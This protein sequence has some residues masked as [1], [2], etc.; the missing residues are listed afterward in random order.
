MS[1]L[2]TKVVV[3]EQVLPFPDPP[4]TPPEKTTKSLELVKVMGWY[5][6][7]GKGNHKIGSKRVLIEPDSVIPLWLEDKAWEGSKISRPSN[8]RI[9]AIKLRG[10]ISPGLLM[11]LE[12]CGLDPLTPVGTE[13]HDLLGIKKYVQPE[14]AQREARSKKQT[15]PR[16][17]HSDFVKMTDIENIKR[18][19]YEFEDGE[20]VDISIKLHGTS[21]RAGWAKTAYERFL[22][23]FVINTDR[24]GKKYI[25]WYIQ[26]NVRVL[27]NR[28]KKFFRLMPE[29]E[30]VVGSR[31][32]E[33]ETMSDSFYDENVWQTVSE[34][35]GLKDILNPGE[36]VYGEIVG[37][38]KSGK[39]VQKNFSYGFKDELAL[40]AYDVRID[41]RWLDR[42]EFYQF[43]NERGI[44]TVTNIYR[45]PYS[46]DVIEK[47][48][49]DHTHPID[50]HNPCREGIVV[51]PIKERISQRVGRLVLKAISDKYYLANTT[52][53]Q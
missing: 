35:N 40:F 38:M 26:E 20:T 34:H 41:G 5:L 52:E 39:S 42:D 2:S 50:K 22:P 9:R 6:V 21:F 3:V 46:F 7:A 8:G 19:N 33:L 1:T 16:R 28:I 47:L 14:Q 10:V 29:N 31:N 37:T 45:G 23:L 18:Y 43:C 27:K 44:N 15:L 11:S 36:F 51:R 49:N 53:Y 24:R 48:R 32:T 25:K 17:L 4:N 13:V 12:D 30:F